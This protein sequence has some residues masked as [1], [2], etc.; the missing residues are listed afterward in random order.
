[1]DESNCTVTIDSA[2]SYFIP[3]Q[4]Y[5]TKLVKKEN[6]G[7]NFFLIK[8]DF[9]ENINEPSIVYGI[10][11]GKTTIKHNGNNIYIDHNQIGEA[12]GLSY[13]IDV[14]KE[15]ILSAE[16]MEVL[17]KFLVDCYNDSKPKQDQDSVN[18]FK[19]GS[20][21]EKLSSLNKRSLET[22]YLEDAVIK[23]YHQ[24]IL[25]FMEQRDE[26]VKYGMPYKRNY[27]FSGVPGTGKTSFIFSLASEINYSIYTIMFTP[28][29]NDDVFSKAL[30][31]IKNNS[32]LVLED[33]DALFIDRDTKNKTFLS[34]S[35]LI[36]IL[37]GLARKEGLII[38]LTTNHIARLDEALIRPGRIDKYL[39]FTY[40][41]QNQIRKMYKTFVPNQMDKIEKFLD[42][43]D[44]IK[45][46]TAI[47]QKF[48]F[49]KRNCDDITL[50]SSIQELKKLSELYVK[51][52]TD[53][54]DFMFN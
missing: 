45:T 12:K 41:T 53:N 17:D 40:A 50:K 28:E 27:L 48:F 9:E 34:F 35:G 18:V 21:W 3:V 52:E 13:K 19:W 37:D 14:Y 30:K 10:P 20:Y 44:T 5:C 36:N 24:D 26:Y 1:M 54:S 42:Q 46:T 29:I 43:V 2:S 11:Y 51:H 31:T 7:A 4:V 47:L 32:I 22:I 23:E 33:V 25:D 16:S 6:N 38:F 15:L 39:E 49:D 8:Y